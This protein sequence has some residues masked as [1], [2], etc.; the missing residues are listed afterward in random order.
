MVWL[1][2]GRQKLVK[3]AG[4]ESVDPCFLL[5]KVILLLAI[6]IFLQEF[7]GFAFSIKCLVC[8][9]ESAWLGTGYEIREILQVY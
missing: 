7:E 5:S 6:S 9:S 2:R 3:P 4:E 8:D 1:T